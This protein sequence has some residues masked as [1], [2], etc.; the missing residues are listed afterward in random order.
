MR[1][2]LR[3]GP[4]RFKPHWGRHVGDVNNQDDK[5]VSVAVDELGDAAKL[6]AQRTVDKSLLLQPD[7]ASGHPVLT[8][9]DSFQPH[10][11]LGDVNS[12]ATSQTLTVGWSGSTRRH[13]SS[14]ETSGSAADCTFRRPDPCA[15]RPPWMAADDWSAAARW[16][17][18]NRRGRASPKI[19]SRYSTHRA[20]SK[21]PF[22][23]GHA[24]ADI[25][26]STFRARRRAETQIGWW[27][28]A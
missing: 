11:A 2:L 14:A 23:S 26:A 28:S 5:V 6:V 3:T 12:S 4:G 13:K 16:T 24:A 7:A 8:G 22:G 19:A 27:V 20:P 17:V 9:L 15:R 21:R 18:C 1:I 10:C 25:D